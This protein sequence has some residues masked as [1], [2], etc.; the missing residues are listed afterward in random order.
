MTLIYNHTRSIQEPEDIDIIEEDWIKKCFVGGLLYSE[1]TKL[2]KDAI[3]ID[4]NSAYPSFLQSSSFRIPIKKGKFTTIEK[5]DKIIKYGIYRVHIIKS[6]DVNI[7]TLFKFNPDNYYTHFDINTAILLGLNISLIQDCQAN[8]L[9]YGE[10]TCVMGCSMFSNL[11]D[12]LMELKMKKVQYAKSLLSQSWGSLC[13]KQKQKKVAYEDFEIP[14]G[15]ILVGARPYNG[16]HLFEYSKLG[17]YFKHNWGRMSCF[18]TAVVRKK[19]ATT[20]FNIKDCIY[21]IHT[22]SVVCNKSNMK[23]IKVKLSKDIGDWKIENEGD[24][25]IF[26]GKAYWNEEIEESDEE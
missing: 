17:Q 23:D 2:I 22:D 11:I 14:N 15:Y 20:C 5:F 10:G 3:C 7:N 21:K 24:C 16:T 26:H 12:L 18:L 1:D 4:I 6:E 19:M 13:E 25:K 9:L 8:A